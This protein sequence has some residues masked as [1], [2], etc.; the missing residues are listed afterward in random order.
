MMSFLSP[1][2][3]A[4]A[5]RTPRE[6]LLL[7]LLGAIIAALAGWYLVAAPL[8]DY[9][10]S[11]RAAYVDAVD[12]YR[13]LSVGIARY[14]SLVTDEADRAAG[15]ARPLRTIV[16]ERAAAMELQ[17]SRMVPDENG[18]LNVWTENVSAA[19]LMDWLADLEQRHAIVA[20]RASIDREGDGLARAQIVLERSGG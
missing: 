12:R 3:E 20:V 10:A 13:A 1:L 15:D 7:G 11:S 16:S 19:R 2:I 9:R 6:Q 5:G 18:R 14:S 8:L 4:W 17:L